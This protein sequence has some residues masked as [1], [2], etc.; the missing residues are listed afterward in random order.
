MAFFNRVNMVSKAQPTGATY[1]QNGRRNY[2]FIVAVL[3]CTVA[4]GGGDAFTIPQG[5]HWC[6]HVS[7]TSE[8]IITG[9]CVVTSD[10]AHP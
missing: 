10:T 6:P 2:L 4:V 5:G 9:S 8:V 1:P 7:P 3:E